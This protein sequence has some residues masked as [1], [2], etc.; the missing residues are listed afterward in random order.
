M[1][2]TLNYEQGGITVNG[3]KD[4]LKE[5]KITQSNLARALG[6]DQTLISQ[7]CHGK[8]KPNVN[9]VDDIITYT[10]IPAETII[11]C[12]RQSEKNA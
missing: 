7:W 8:C 9:Q 5:K 6:V 3:F 1:S 4:L 2:V 11:A 10:G 12:F